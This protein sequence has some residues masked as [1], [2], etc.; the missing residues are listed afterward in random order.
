MG[1]TVTRN[2]NS[3]LTYSQVGY[4]IPRPV[5]ATHQTAASCKCMKA[6][7]VALNIFIASGTVVSLKGDLT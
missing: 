2:N 5:N 1:V 4:V 3:L 7:D 6:M